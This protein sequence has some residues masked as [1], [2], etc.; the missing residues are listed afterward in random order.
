MISVSQSE[1]GSEFFFFLFQIPGSLHKTISEKLA[2]LAQTDA[3]GN[4]M[5]QVIYRTR[6]NCTVFISDL[7]SSFR[8]TGRKI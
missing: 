8:A 5:L 3:P 2:M 4:M 7:Q 1:T 6:Q